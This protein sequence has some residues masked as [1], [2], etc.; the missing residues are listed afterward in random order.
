[1][2][3]KNIIRLTLILS[4]V[5]LKSLALSCAGFTDQEMYENY[6]YVYV[7]EIL[8]KEDSV[9]KKGSTEYH[10]SLIKA[11]KN[12][13]DSSK[14]LSVKYE[15]I[16]NEEDKGYDI[17]YDAYTQLVVGEEYVIFGNY[18]KIPNN[19]LCREFPKYYDENIN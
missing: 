14:A 2:K 12:Y 11:L 3:K 19:E 4:A 15:P 13:P 8:S 18:G 6:D 16:I 5:S 9:I 7:G 10:V 17:N 1:M